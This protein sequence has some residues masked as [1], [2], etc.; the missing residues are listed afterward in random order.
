MLRQWEELPDCMRIPEVRPYWEVLYNKRIQLMV[1]R[2]V[3][4]LLAWFMLVV[5]ALPMVFIAIVIKADSK[6][7]VFFRQVRVT[8]YGKVF[9]IHKLRTMIVDAEKKGTGVTVCQDNRITKAGQKLRKYRL[10]EL[11]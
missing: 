9:R 7:P 11:P 10:D 4:M 8:Q 1:K 3:D 5:F 2:L 6:G